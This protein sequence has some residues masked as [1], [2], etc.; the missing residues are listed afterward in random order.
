MQKR[1][2]RISAFLC[3]FALLVT[4]VLGSSAMVL[5]KATDSQE[6]TPVTLDGFKNITISDFVDASEN[7]MEEKEYTN[8][9]ASFFAKDI[10]NFDK[11]LLSMKV[12]FNSGSPTNTIY[13]GGTGGYTGFNFRMQAGSGG[14]MLIT[15]DNSSNAV[16]PYNLGGNR[17]VINASDAGGADFTSFLNNEFLLQFSFEF[18]TPDA[19]NKADLKLGVYINGVLYKDAPYTISG[20]DMTKVGNSMFVACGANESITLKS[21][22]IES[23]EPPVNPPEE[24]DFITFSEFGV[25]DGVY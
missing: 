19:N 17:P 21:V 5:V 6:P 23:E 8:V 9:A 4:T 24:K 25:N 11:T 13:L 14:W 10:P 1:I 2:K 3:A 18:G 12:K 20:F 7:P 16:V 22:V 15:N